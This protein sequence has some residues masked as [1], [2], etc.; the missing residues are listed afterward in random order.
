MLFFGRPDRLMA[1]GL[2]AAVVVSACAGSDERISDGAETSPSLSAGDGVGRSSSDDRA[3]VEEWS[4]ESCRDEEHS[5]LWEWVSES[6]DRVEVAGM[7]QSDVLV[8]VSSIEVVGAVRIPVDTSVDGDID[9]G[10]PTMEVSCVAWLELGVSEVLFADYEHSE[11]R[12]LSARVPAVPSVI[13][14]ADTWPALV[15]LERGFED[16]AA[17]PESVVVGLTAGPGPAIVAEPGRWPDFELSIVA[18][19]AA[20]WMWYPDAAVARAASDRMATVRQRLGVTSI[21]ELVAAFRSD[22]PW[23][24]EEFPDL[25]PPPERAWDQDDELASMPFGLPAE[26]LA[27]LE[28]IGVDVRPNLIGF[29]DD[30]HFGGSIAIESTSGSRVGFGL[31]LNVEG[32]VAPIAR[33]ADEQLSVMW[34]PSSDEH[35]SPVEIGVVRDVAPG[36]IAV[37]E[38]D[39]PLGGETTV[40]S[41]STRLPTVEELQ[42]ALTM[43][44]VR[45]DGS[46]DPDAF[47]QEQRADD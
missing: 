5:T 38:F 2:V 41:I 34:M 10:M 15:A 31:S 47:A 26:V 24:Q 43:F 27:E 40:T 32:F 7:A 22:L 17:R 30:S 25:Y 37:I 3:M 42:L 36:Q 21:V 12:D 45:P 44:G 35:A 16:I 8:R 1:L 39:V 14:V 9:D 29:R 18:N 13:R 23:W 19:E 33:F 28:V 11:Y 46:I 4:D 20:D 6:G